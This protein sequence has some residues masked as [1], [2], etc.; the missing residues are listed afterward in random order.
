M[1]SP[2]YTFDSV[3]TKFKNDYPEHWP[4]YV[5]MATKNI[6]A[7]QR[8]HNLDYSASGM[9]QAVTYSIQITDG[10]ATAA[11]YVVAAGIMTRLQDLESEHIA[12]ELRALRIE[13]QQERLAH[14]NNLSDTHKAILTTYYNHCLAKVSAITDRIMQQTIALTLSLG[15]KEPEPADN[16][17]T[18]NRHHGPRWGNRGDAVCA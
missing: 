14:S 17:P 16:T 3:F 18:Y 1:E 9:R 13:Q 2:K 10:H 4:V 6:K 7:A 8:K 5:R 11:A 12:T 15:I